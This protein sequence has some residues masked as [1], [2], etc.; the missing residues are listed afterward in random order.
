[1]KALLRT[2][3]NIYD[4]LGYA[5]YKEADKEFIDEL[6]TYIPVFEELA[7]AIE[8]EVL[9]E[10]VDYLSCISQSE[11]PLLKKQFARIFLSTGYAAHLKTAIPQESVYRSPRQISM[12]DERDAVLEIYYSEGIG[13]N[14]SFTEPDD[15]ITA[16]FHF[17][18]QMSAKAEDLDEN[19]M[20][21]NLEVQLNFLKEHINKWVPRVCKDVFNITEI[22]YFRAIAKLTQG[23]IETDTQFLEEVVSAKLTN[24]I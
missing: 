13:K 11:Y 1:M 7:E 10:G 19:S 15:H 4:L 3:K 22:N 20:F 8:N 5:F 17:M 14:K 23:F 21:E 9:H 18:A 12:Q 2:R 24:K 16:E 6:K